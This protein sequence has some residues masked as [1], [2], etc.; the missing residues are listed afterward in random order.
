[1]S[2]IEW[3]CAVP[4][5]LFY[6]RKTK[7]PRVG[8]SQLWPPVLSTGCSQYFTFPPSRWVSHPAETPPHS[9]V[10]QKRQ[11]ELSACRLACC[12]RRATLLAPRCVTE[13]YKISILKHTGSNLCAHTLVAEQVMF[14]NVWMHFRISMTSHS[15]VRVL[16]PSSAASSL[17]QKYMDAWYAGWCSRM[18]SC[19][20][21]NLVVGI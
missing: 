10:L 2:E 15:S 18:L 12:C 1:M 21:E 19:Y 3:W 20:R 9:T 13:K 7:S 5:A 14:L 16:L 4:A 8:C 17:L 6:C 11:P